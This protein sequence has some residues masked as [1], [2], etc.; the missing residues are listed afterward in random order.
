M[1]DHL[2]EEILELYVLSRLPPAEVLRVNTHLSSCPSCQARAAHEGDIA[3]DVLSTAEP[4][5]HPEA[6]DE[7]SPAASDP[8]FLPRN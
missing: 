6:L 2:D 1:P 4:D 7:T 3:I 8:P 5:S